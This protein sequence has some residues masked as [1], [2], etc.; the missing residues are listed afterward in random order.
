MVFAGVPAGP[1]TETPAPGSEQ[2]PSVKFPIGEAGAIEIP[3]NAN[4][5]TK[6]SGHETVSRLATLA[7]F[8]HLYM[9]SFLHEV[10]DF[11]PSPA[12]K[13]HFY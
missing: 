8:L 4:S 3:P 6:M 11:G 10:S 13:A 2:M 9:R 12:L 5:S 1:D 7:K